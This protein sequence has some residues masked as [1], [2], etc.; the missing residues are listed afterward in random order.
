V[1]RSIRLLTPEG[2]AVQPHD[3]SSPVALFSLDTETDFGTGRTEALDQIDRFADLMGELDVP[4]TAFVEG[5]FFEDRPALCRGLEARG[6][7]LQV[8]CHDHADPGDTPESLVRSVA[9]YAD[10]LG[11]RPAGYRAHTYRLTRPLYDT[12]VAEGFAWDS[13]LMRAFAQGSNRHP[14]F[15]AGDYLVF[16]KQFFEFPVGTWNG[17]PIPFN[18]TH[19]L[20]AKRLGETTLRALFGPSRL[21]T[22]NLHM[23]DL[24]RCRS[25]AHAQRTPIVRSLYRY[26]WSLQGA[27]T[28]RVVR[29]I[30]GDLRRRHYE[31]QTTN[32]LYR[33]LKRT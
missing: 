26:M 16:D 31:F 8:H 24:V 6:V 20:L 15:R 3:L 19:V 21:A 27:D 1:A 33:K 28:F 9:A 11:R 22:Y 14:G 23:T 5:R 17:M 25:L 12:L 13:S 7:D 18:H 2:L 4:W 30:V 29:R 10:C 32:G